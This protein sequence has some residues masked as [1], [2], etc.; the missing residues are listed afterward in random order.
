MWQIKKPWTLPS[1]ALYNGHIIFMLHNKIKISNLL[2][3]IIPAT[4]YNKK[5]YT[6]NL[7]ILGNMQWDLI[8]LLLLNTTDNSPSK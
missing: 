2:D 5:I 7:C 3:H 8:K 4:P 1:E 6:K